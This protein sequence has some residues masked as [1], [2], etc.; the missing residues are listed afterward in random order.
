MPSW[1]R[2]RR[3]TTCYAQSP[4]LSSVARR[5]RLTLRPN[6]EARSLLRAVAQ[7][8]IDIVRQISSPERAEIVSGLIASDEEDI[9]NVVGAISLLK[10]VPPATMELVTGY[11]EVWSAMTMHAYLDAQG[12]TTAWLDA[13]E[14]LV[15]DNAGTGLGEKGST[16]V[17]AP[18]PA[19]APPPP[20]LAGPRTPGT[21]TASPTAGRPRS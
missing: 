1:T 12:H 3:R 16:N 5:Q 8:Q 9:I 15:V 21:R 17:T 4:W 2:L 11:G 10:M 20:L 19:R 6:S 13:R 14:V 18:Q 7:E